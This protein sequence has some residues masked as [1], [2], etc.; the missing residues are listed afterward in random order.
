MSILFRHPPHPKNLAARNS[1]VDRQLIECRS[2]FLRYFRRRLACPEDAEDA[3]QEFSLKVIRAANTLQDDEKIDAWFGRILRNTLTDQYR[4]RA[5]RQRAEA[6]YALEPKE[7]A[8]D[9]EP[10]ATPCTCVHDV[11]PAL[12]PDYAE[13]IRRADLDETPRE[14]VAADLGVT[15]NN[16]GVRLHR[17]RRALKTELEERCAGCCD[18]GFQSCDCAGTGES[19][20]V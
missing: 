2:E 1:A 4:R 14:R 10:V 12:K 18:G 9:P 5:T 13:I 3:V 16:V 6:G 7:A 8:V 17:A 11:L 19:R 15:A 20:R